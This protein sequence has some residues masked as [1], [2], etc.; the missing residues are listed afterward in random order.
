[1][2]LASIIQTSFAVIIHNLNLY[3]MRKT[4]LTYGL[5]SGAAAAV[6]MVATA[7]YSKNANN[8]E[9]GAI[10]GYAGI[11]LSMMFVFLGVRAYR[12]GVLEGSISFSKAFQV[13]ILITVISCTCYVLAWFYVYDNLMPD[14][15]DKY[16]ANA[17]EQM[18][19]SGATAEHISEQTKQMEEYKVMYQN[20]L[21]RFALTFIEPFPVGLLVTIISAA[22]LRRQSA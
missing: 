15:L 10:F 19:Q 3:K 1:M 2:M 6:L 14:F 9:N 17:L 16:I 12:N 21:T 20:P 8:F 18:K 11:L 13:G 5:L 7:L 4:I 22:V